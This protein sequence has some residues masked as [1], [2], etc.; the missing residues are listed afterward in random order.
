MSREERLL[1]ADNSKRVNQGAKSQEVFAH[2]EQFQS[3]LTRERKM[4]ISSLFAIKY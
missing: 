3:L 2:L 1:D 4:G